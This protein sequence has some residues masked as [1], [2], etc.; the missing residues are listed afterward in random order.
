VKLD[1]LIVQH[2]YNSKKV[3]LMGIGNFHLDPSVAL[4]SESDKD[5]VMPENAISFEYDLKAPED[6]GLSNFVGE[7][8]R[9]IK[10]LA[11]SDLESYSILAKQFLNIGKPLVIEGIGTIQKNQA[12]IYEFRPGNFIA[13]RVADVPKQL[14]EK[15]EDSKVSFESEKAVKTNKRGLMIVL[16]LLLTAIVGAAMYYFLVHNN[17]TSTEPV[18]EQT[19]VVADTASLATTDSA[20]KTTTD[21]T[22]LQPPPVETKTDSNNF[23]IVLKEYNNAIAANKA[24]GKLSSYGHKLELI[25]TDSTNFKIAMPFTLPLS[26]TTRTRDSL[27]KFFGGSPYILIKQ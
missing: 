17:E 12:G 1:N 14:V 24:Y 7:K 4:P 23:R 16:A 21:S 6:G 18:N 3:S 2:L 11:T 8:T 19:E 9:K 25:T 13:P 5:Y 26:D 22:A 10:P 15:A 20:Q 27:R